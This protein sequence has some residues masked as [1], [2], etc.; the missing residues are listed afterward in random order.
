MRWQGLLIYDMYYAIIYFYDYLW[1][2]MRNNDITVLI[3]L[4]CDLVSPGMLTHKP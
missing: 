1:F 2:L 4:L 3:F